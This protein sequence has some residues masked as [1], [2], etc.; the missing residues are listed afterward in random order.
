VISKGNEFGLS[1]SPASLSFLPEFP[2]I[3]KPLLLF[4]FLAKIGFLSFDFQ[5]NDSL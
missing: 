2:D 3:E 5:Q 4:F 1:W